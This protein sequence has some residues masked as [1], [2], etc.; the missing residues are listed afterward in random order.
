M[1]KSLIATSLILLLGASAAM[2]GHG[3]FGG[4][5]LERMKTA[6]GLSEIQSAQVEVIMQEQRAQMQA[7][8]ATTEQRI[9][10]LLT[11]DQAAKFAEMK[12]KREER[13]QKRQ[14]RM[15]QR[16]GQGGF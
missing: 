14:E 12:Q 7:L 16:H 8:R 3:G 13:K 5:G 2:A 10:A 15:Q 6:L 11:P 1:K 4:K 9:Q